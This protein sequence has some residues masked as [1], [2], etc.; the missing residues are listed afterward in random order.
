LDDPDL[1]YQAIQQP[2]Y[3]NVSQNLLRKFNGSRLEDLEKKYLIPESVK[4]DPPKSKPDEFYL[5]K[6]LSLTK[7]LSFKLQL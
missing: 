2:I 3:R 4:P 7:K 6:F 1:S 5:N